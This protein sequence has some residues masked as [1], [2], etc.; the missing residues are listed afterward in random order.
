M[1]CRPHKQRGAALI[2][3]ATVL[4]IGIAWFAV[5]ALGKAA[6][7]T[8]DKQRA[9]GLALNAA[10]QALLAHV[11]QYAARSTTTEP[12]QIPCPE[13]LNWASAGTEGQA[14]T[15]CSNGIETVGRLPWKTLG[16][17]QLRDS[18]GEPLWYVLS[19]GFRN[20]PVNFG[21][22]GQ[23]T[24]NGIG[25]AA[26]ALI[27]APGAPLN[28]A[29]D[30]ATPSAPCSKVNQQSGNRNDT[31]SPMDPTKFLECGNAAGPYGN[32]GNVGWSQWSNDRVIAITQAEW[33]DAIAGPIADRLQRQVAVA[34]GDWRTTQ[35]VA[36]WGTSFLPNASTINPGDSTS[37]P[38][39]ND[40][41]GDVD[42]TEGMPPTASAMSGC[43]TAWTGGS[44]TVPLQLTF[45][46]C[47]PTGTELRCSFPFVL[48]PGLFSPTITATAPNIAHA[49]RSFG[50]SQ[51]MIEVSG[52]PPQSASVSGYTASVSAADGSGTVSFQIAFPLLTLIDSVVVRLPNP[53]DAPMFTDTKTQWF[54]ANNWDRYTYYTVS[55]AAT[56]NP[57]GSVCAT[58]G[59]PGCITVNGFAAST[60]STNDKRLVLALMGR[61]L[62]GHTQPS[63][64]PT[65]YLESRV[66]GT[67]FTSATVTKTYN[68]RLAACPFQYTPQPGPAIAVCN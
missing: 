2:I 17:N 34:L 18:D 67:Q 44:A 40:L 63:T 36:N 65:D 57:A 41:C 66:S 23:I 64:S 26:V 51:V 49:F 62:P 21:T 16:I 42:E 20:P 9:T 60:G 7:T 1:R 68:D 55:R 15:S 32:P 13:S 35:S 12:G 47:S 48:F 27:V 38:P 56:A 28:T 4:I 45:S 29:S 50:A 46:G 58:A 5:G 10:K 53:S 19:R 14:S 11:A 3:W 6:R 59:D 33:A 24:Y 25:N 31:A 43:N 61:V 22:P 52:G 37:A 54:F 30:P 8:A 39:T